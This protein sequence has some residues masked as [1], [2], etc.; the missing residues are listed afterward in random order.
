MK[1]I[2]TILLLMAVTYSQAQLP[3]SQTPENKNVVLEE[4][5]GFHCPNCPD[6]HKR[7][8]QIHDAHPDDVILI[9]IHTGGYASPQAGEPDFRTSFGPALASQSQLY[10]YPAGT[11]NRHYFGHSQYGSPSGATALGR[12]QWASDS[13]TTLG[14]PSYL[15]VALEATIDVQ[16]RE[17]IVNVE[18]Y[19]TGNSPEA[20]NYLN[21]ALLQDNIEGPQ[22]GSNGNPNQVL[23][24]GNYNHTHMLRHLLTGQW[25]DVISTTSQGTLVQR[26]YTYTLPADINA[27]PL[28]LGN[29]EVVAFVAE[30]HQEII[31]GN[32]GPISI[33]GLQ[34]TTNAMAQQAIVTDEICNASDLKPKLVVSNNGSSEITSL[35]IE[36]NVNSGAAQTLNWTGSINSLGIK[37]ID[38]PDVVFT[39]NATNTLNA[40]IAS[41]NGGADENMADDIASVNFSKTPNQGLGT[42]YIVEIVQDRYGDESS[43]V[44]LDS[45]GNVIANGGPY[46]ELSSNGTQT[47]T[48]NVT[49]SNSDCYTFYMLD[50]YGDGMNGRF[51]AGNYSLKQA[52]GTVVL[53]GDGIF[54][55]QDVQHFEVDASSGIEDAVFK[56]LK[57]YPN[58]ANNIIFVNNGESMDLEISD[59]N[60]QVLYNASDMNKNESIDV[61][62]FAKGVYI[63]RFVKGDKV[64]SQKLIIN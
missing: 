29:L 56:D 16:T 24:N 33:T 20:N 49:L 1:Q 37:T 4:F 5:T 62:S 7:A 43:W 32:K 48:H 11:V 31:S 38:L 61:S 46:S 55:S 12:G 54:A 2:I 28:D 22:S 17:M 53:H 34:Y 44:I 36:Y 64:G 13:S 41:V 51:G 6:G 45:N 21:V 8:Q 59:V 30:N 63:M 42:D 25:G 50:S 60:G 58:P 9:N 27:V 3:V 19:Y 14:Q 52:D 23:P 10:G 15:N 57:V 35:E 26:Q 40:V 39:I 47:H 18:V